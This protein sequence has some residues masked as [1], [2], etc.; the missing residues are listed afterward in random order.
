MIYCA[1][2]NNETFS[3]VLQQEENI[4]KS[5]QDM[6]NGEARA[7]KDIQQE[8]GKAALNNSMIGTSV[9]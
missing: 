5:S 7:V 9:L 2:K 6:F 8:Q 4:E 3:N 1:I